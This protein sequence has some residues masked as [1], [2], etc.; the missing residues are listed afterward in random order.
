MEA[1]LVQAIQVAQNFALKMEAPLTDP[2][3]IWA[4]TF[5]SHQEAFHHYVYLW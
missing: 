5:L 2:T 4:M 1:L 3:T